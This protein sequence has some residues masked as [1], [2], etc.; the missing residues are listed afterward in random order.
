M[1]ERIEF[2]KNGDY[3]LATIP[4]TV[5]T[6]QRAQ[7]ILTRIATECSRLNY[8][9]VILD[10]RSVESREVPPY[11][12]L[13]L[14]HHMTDQGLDKIYMAFWCQPHLINDDSNLL[15]LFTFKNEFVVQHFSEK[16]EALAW[17]KGPGNS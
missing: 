11:E 15:S 13:K 12:I 3:L 5:I 16:K 14:G 8:Q 10:E 1:S 6:T 17:L 2:E 7:E 4:D 9:S